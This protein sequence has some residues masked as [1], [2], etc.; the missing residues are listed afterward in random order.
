MEPQITAFCAG[1]DGAPLSACGTFSMRPRTGHVRLSAVSAADPRPN[2]PD[3]GGARAVVAWLSALV[4][5]IGV[6]GAFIPLRDHVAAADIA[7]LLAVVILLAATLGGRVVGAVA[8]V[9]AA[10]AFDLFFT[11]PYYS[12]RI[13]RAEDVETAVLMLIVGVAIGEIVTRGKRDRFAAHVSRSNLER[14]SRIT[15]LAAGGEPPGRLI[16]VARRE[17]LDLLDLNDAEFE[18]P[19][20]FDALPRLNHSGLSIPPSLGIDTR[21][22]TKRSS[23][24]ELPIWAE[25]LE[26]GR[27]VLT[28]ADD[29][30]GLEFA[31]EARTS[32]LA[33]ADRLGVALLAHDR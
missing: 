21:A 23:K 29:A 20:F 10:F 25:G 7:L 3:P 28:L 30:T 19:P 12:L 26:V 31:P 16:R 18:R 33:L 27:F 15:E 6:A 11:R 4:V 22:D 13:N 14:V 1:S 9:E 24:I 17:L 32:A 5:P 8:A 2:P